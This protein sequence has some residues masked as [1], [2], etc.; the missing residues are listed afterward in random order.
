MERGTITELPKSIGENDDYSDEDDDN[1]DVSDNSSEDHGDDN[2][3]NIDE[4]EVEKKTENGGWDLH[5]FGF[6]CHQ[7]N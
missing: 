3:E 5:L 7:G 6:P 4:D 2:D 1:D